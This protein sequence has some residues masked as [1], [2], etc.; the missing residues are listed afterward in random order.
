MMRVQQA[1][2]RRARLPHRDKATA[3]LVA[4]IRFSRD[5]E[6]LN[7]QRTSDARSQTGYRLSR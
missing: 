1:E 3:S 2:G 5:I 4:R 7:I 6:Q